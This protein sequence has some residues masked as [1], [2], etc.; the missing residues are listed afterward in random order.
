MSRFFFYQ[1]AAA[2]EEKER[3]KIQRRTLRDAAN[4]F[5]MPDEE[6]RHIYRFR[7]EVVFYLCGELNVDLQPHNGDGLPTH[8]KVLT[9]LHLLADGNYQRGTGQDHG[10]CIGQTTVSRYLDQF[11]DAVNRRLKDQ[12][13]IFPGNE[14]SRRS[15]ATG[16]EE[17]YRLPNIL[18][19]VDCTQV[20]IFPPPLPH[21]V[22]YLNR[23]GVHALNVQLVADVNCKI[24]AVNAR[25]PGR[26]HD[27][28]I[29]NNSSIKDE[30]R[31]LYNG[32]IGDYFLLGDSGYALEP[33]LMTPVLNPA[34]GSPEARYTAWHCR[35]RNIIERTNGYLKNVFRCLGHDRVLHYSPAKASSMINVCCVLYNIMQYYRDLPVEI[36][37]EIEEGAPQELPHRHAQN[38]HLLRVAQEKRARL[39]N[40]YF[41]YYYVLL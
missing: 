17:A 8:F 14:R 24:L 20:K 6:F 19:A 22:Q 7:K 18:G 21:G 30:L 36:L 5:D 23:K 34:Q 29:F 13:I 41:A 28:F 4:P 40:T 27:S 26:V 37:E 3:R 32:H 11:V 31:R 35:V 9:A 39:I 25:F 33:W 16:F 1:H 12:W 2:A 38:G 15:V 10:L